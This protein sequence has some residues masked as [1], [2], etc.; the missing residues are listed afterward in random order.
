MLTSWPLHS[1]CRNTSTAIAS[2]ASAA[3]TS[4]S[5]APVAWP[6]FGHSYR[7]LLSKPRCFCERFTAWTRCGS[8]P[9]VP[10]AALRQPACSV[11]S[12]R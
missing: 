4:L 1:R 9:L 11:G 2:V 8:V 10:S 7:Y 6:Q 12:S 3:R 5:V